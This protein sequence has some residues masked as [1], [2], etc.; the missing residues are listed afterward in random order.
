MKNITFNLLGFHQPHYNP[1]H[2]FKGN[3]LQI[4]MPGVSQ[5]FS[6]SYLHPD[7]SKSRS[8]FDLYALQYFSEALDFQYKWV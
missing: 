8:G 3:L 7:G 5:S 1:R 4:V 2:S 6:K